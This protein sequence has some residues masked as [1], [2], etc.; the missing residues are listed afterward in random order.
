VSKAQSYQA[1]SRMEP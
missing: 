1:D